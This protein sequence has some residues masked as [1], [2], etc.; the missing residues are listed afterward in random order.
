MKI[1]ILGGAGFLGTHVVLRYL[2]DS[3]TE[4]TVIDSL[5]P[6]FHSSLSN[7]ETRGDRIQFVQG[8]LRDEELLRKYVVKQDIIINCAAQSSHVLSIR[9]PLLDA[10]INCLGNLKLLEAVRASNPEAVLIYPSSTT[11]VGKSTEEVADERHQER[12]MEIYSAHKAVI[13]KYYQIYHALYGLRTVILRFANLYGPFGK[14]YPEFCFVNYFIELARQGREIQIFGTGEQI[15][16][17]TYVGDA[18]EVIWRAPQCKSSFGEV[19]FAVSPYYY[20]VKEVAEE[21]ITTFEKGRISYQ[22]WPA[23]R[24]LIEIDPIRFSS[25]KLRD[26]IGWS[27]Q[28]DLKSGL[29][30]TKEILELQT[31]GSRL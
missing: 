20:S 3:G 27:P 12:P 9:Y 10:E 29:Q 13:E 25:K 24:K 14:G 22:P 21:I 30:K 15:R 17:V 4:L 26:I 31:S 8:D 16:N 18:A 7:L 1:L 5:D 28:Y 19:C 2:E 23:E 11:V 6:R